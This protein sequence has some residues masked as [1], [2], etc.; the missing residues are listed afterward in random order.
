MIERRNPAEA[1]DYGSDVQAGHTQPDYDL[2]GMGNEA[3][4]LIL[5]RL[6]E[7]AH[8]AGI[9]LFPEREYLARSVEAN[10]K[11][12]SDVEDYDHAKDTAERK[13]LEA[14]VDRMNPKEGGE[15]A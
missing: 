11:G 6:S 2:Y 5:D 4:M 15:N 13:A 10:A 8:L 12:A 7:S 3:D 1:D 9:A 14:I